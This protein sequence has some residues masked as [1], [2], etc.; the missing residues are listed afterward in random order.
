LPVKPRNS[1][2]VRRPQHV[3][4]FTNYKA[5]SL[6]ELRRK[7]N[8][9]SNM[10]LKLVQKNVT[11]KK[12]PPNCRKITDTNN[13]QSTRNFWALISK[14]QNC[15]AFTQRSRVPRS[16]THT[17]THTHTHKHTHTSARGWLFVCSRQCKRWRT[18]SCYCFK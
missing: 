15:A 6:D 18:S 10:Y 9:F 17:H 1:R 5:S 7:I 2:E 11:N 8:Y 16:L 4:V 12:I 3:H 14:N 13:S